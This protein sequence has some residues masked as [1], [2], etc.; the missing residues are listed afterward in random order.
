MDLITIKQLAEDDRPR[1]KMMMKG[2]RALSDAELIAILIGSG[3]KNETAIQLSQRILS[4]CKNDIN[5]LA[6]L[7]LKELCG[8]K[9][10]GLAKAVSISAALELGRRR[11]TTEPV[12][13]SVLT[14]SSSAFALLSPVLRDLPNEEFWMLILNRANKLISKEPVSKG[15]INATLVDAR[16]IFKPAILQNASSIIL[17]HNHPS[18][19]LKPSEEDIKLTKKLKDA[20]KLLDINVIDHLII[21]E[22]NYFRFADEGLL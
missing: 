22:N 9:G 5:Q 11:D 13:R 14:S 20:G 17:A 21:A 10:I 6:K 7:T 18:G 12:E 15:G 1:E 16:M 3:N 8:F 4:E 19:N 2:S